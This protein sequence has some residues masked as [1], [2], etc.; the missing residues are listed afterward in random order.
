MARPVPRR[1]PPSGAYWG[2]RRGEELLWAGP[3]SGR[4][5]E[6]AFVTRTEFV[7]DGGEP[8]GMAHNPVL[9]R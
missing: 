5:D 6:S 3:V 7:I 1:M 8:A 2:Q 4:G 9:E